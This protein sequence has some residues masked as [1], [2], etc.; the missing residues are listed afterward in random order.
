MRQTAFVYC[1]TVF[2]L[3]PVRRWLTVGGEFVHLTE[4]QFSILLHLV[5]NAPEIVDHDALAQAGWGGT[6]SDNSVQQAISRLRKVLVER[7][8]CAFI[9]TVPNRGYRF[10]ASAGQRTTTT[11]PESDDAKG[12]AARVLS[13]RCPRLLMRNSTEVSIGA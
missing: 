1:F 3:D 4:S 7:G 2:E 9:E 5:S 11:S 13:T 6:T 8:G 12:S 10:T